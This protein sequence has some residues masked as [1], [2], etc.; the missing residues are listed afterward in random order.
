VGKPAEVAEV[1]WF[2]AGAAASYISGQ[3]VVVDGGMT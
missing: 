1:V 3:A 2:L